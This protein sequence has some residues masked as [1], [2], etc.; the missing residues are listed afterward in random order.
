MTEKV[1]AYVVPLALA[2]ASSSSDEIYSPVKRL[3]ISRD[4]ESYTRF[5]HWGSGSRYPIPRTWMALGI[6]V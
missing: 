3:E 5:W 2:V 4:I 1:L 6:I